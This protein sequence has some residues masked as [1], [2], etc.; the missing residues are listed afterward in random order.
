MSSIGGDLINGSLHEVNLCN[1]G[2]IM[3]N[4]KRLG[5]KDG[6]GYKDDN[7]RFGPLSFSDPHIRPGRQ[8]LT[9]SF[10]A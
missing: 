6:P 1:Y 7:P 3:V 9:D 10:L 5:T 8:F 2:Q 4:Y